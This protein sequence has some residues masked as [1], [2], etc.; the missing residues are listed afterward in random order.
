MGDA[1]EERRRTRKASIQTEEPVVA[2]VPVEE[3]LVEPTGEKKEGGR[4]GMVHVNN[5]VGNKVDGTIEAQERR[6]KE[7]NEDLEEGKDEVSAVCVSPSSG[8]G[9]STPTEDSDSCNSIRHSPSTY[10][11]EEKGK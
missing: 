4:E 11:G 7:E 5:S 6:R 9:D 3:V 8:T 1:A 2:A 10:D